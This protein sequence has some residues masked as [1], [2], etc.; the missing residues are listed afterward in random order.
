VGII[1]TFRSDILAR[2][3]AWLGLLLA[4][5]RLVFAWLLPACL[6]WFPACCCRLPV[7]VVTSGPGRG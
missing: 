3:V 2:A 4:C 1:F 7:V 6:A 5:V